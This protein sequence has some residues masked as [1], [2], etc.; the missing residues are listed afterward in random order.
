[1]SVA[2]IFAALSALGFAIGNVFIRIGIERVSPRA[3]TFWT[4]LTG[5][6]LLTSLA[7]ALNLTEIK[8][9][10]LSTIGWFALMGAMLI[11]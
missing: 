3:A 4:V 2:I 8:A 9:L 1:M 6:I 5:A 7:F 11:R 10:K